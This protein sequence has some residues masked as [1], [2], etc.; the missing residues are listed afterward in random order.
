MEDKRKTENSREQLL[1]DIIAALGWDT[2]DIYCVDANSGV[3]VPYRLSG[4]AL[5][6]SE[7]LS[8]DLACDELMQLYVNANVHPED[9]DYML[10]NSKLSFV[11]YELSDKEHFHIHYRILR[12][13]EVHHYV[14]KC[15]RVGKSESVEKILFVFA[16][17]DKAYSRRQ[18]VENASRDELTGVLSRQAFLSEARKMLDENPNTDYDV[19]I[20]D[21]ENFKIV[22]AVYGEAKGDEVLKYLADFTQEHMCK[23]GILGRISADRFV[24]LVPARQDEDKQR[25][26]KLMDEAKNNA[27]VNINIK[28]GIYANVDRTLAVSVMCDRALLAVKSIKRNFSIP[29]ATY[30]GPVSVKHMKAQM[31][32]AHFDRAIKEKEFDVWFQPKYDAGTEYVVGAE[33]LVRWKKSDGVFIPPA[34][35]I[36]T[37]EQDGLIVNLDEYV[38]R[39][40]CTKLRFWLDA[41]IN[42]L[43]I[44]VNLSRSSLH[45]QGTIKKYKSI[46]EELNVPIEKVPL[47]ITESATIRDAGIK[48]LMQELRDAGFVLHMDDFGSGLS[49]LSSINMLP[50]NVLKLDKSLVDYIGDRGGEEL[51]KHTVSLAH[52]KDL[53][54]IAEGVED[55]NQLE[56]LKQIGVDEIQGYYFS[57][58]MPYDDLVDYFK[59]IYKNR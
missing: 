50:I 4:E 39:T 9:R 35:F 52:F 3:V 8:L 53:K 37:F 26:L 49:S 45:H 7:G 40:V 29:Y 20:S 15:I 27:P 41:G 23:D 11:R 12:N 38:F 51:L 28:Y 44:S 31:Y 46:I 16:L 36:P 55:R 14:L 5:A 42:V 34:E 13:G 33:A 56:F 58:P 32:E 54:V 6:V 10:R 18:F 48:D 2:S 1:L 43:P 24:W 21:V 57:K 19:T 25:F 59:K 47:E 17:E 30:D 22:N